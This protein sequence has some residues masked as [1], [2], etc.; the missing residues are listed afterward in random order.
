LLVLTNVPI[1]L[2]AASAVNVGVSAAIGARFATNSVLLSEQV[3]EARG[4]MMSFS[5]AL[6]GAAI[7]TGASIGGLLIDTAGFWLIGVFCASVGLL[8]A[9]IVT[10]F[11]VEEPIDLETQVA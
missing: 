3:P 10:L 5:A 6:S 9:A 7:V 1:G 11:V 4:T 8:S 2:I